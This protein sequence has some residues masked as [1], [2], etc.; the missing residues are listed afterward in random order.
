MTDQKFS[1]NSTAYV[2]MESEY[3]CWWFLFYFHAGGKIVPWRK[4]G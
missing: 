3:L 1:G 4:R 2:E